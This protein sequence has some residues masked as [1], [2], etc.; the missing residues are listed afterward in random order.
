MQNMTYTNCASFM[1]SL[2]LSHHV[3]LAVPHVLNRTARA[4]VVL[5]R[6]YVPHHTPCCLAGAKVTAWPGATLSGIR[7]KL[8][9]ATLSAGLAEQGRCNQHT[10]TQQLPQAHVHTPTQQQSQSKR[11]LEQ[12]VQPTH[13]VESIEELGTPRTMQKEQRQGAADGEDRWRR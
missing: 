2:S 4:L 8:S 10:H 3:G 11:R 13:G 1:H 7:E 12:Q 9:P 5:R 6:S